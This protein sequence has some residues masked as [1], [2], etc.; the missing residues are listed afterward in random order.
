MQLD[1]LKNAD[2]AIVNVNYYSTQLKKALSIHAK[3][4]G[5]K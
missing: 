1:A 3:M 4:L 5:I 2:F